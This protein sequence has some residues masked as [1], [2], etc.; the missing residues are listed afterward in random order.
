METSSNSDG[1]S[2][3]RMVGNRAASIDL[4]APGGPTINMLL[5]QCQTQQPAK[6]YAPARNLVDCQCQFAG[7]FSRQFPQKRR[8]APSFKKPLKP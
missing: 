8:G 5:C 2:G 7:S 6:H 3:G 4:P 1:A